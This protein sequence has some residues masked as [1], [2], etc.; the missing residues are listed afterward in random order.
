MLIQKDYDVNIFIDG[1]NIFEA[2]GVVLKEARILEGFDILIPSC[3]LSLVVPLGWIN[4]R[5]IVDGTQIRIDIISKR[6]DI[7]ESLYFRLFDISKIAIEQAFCTI[8]LGGILDFYPGYRFYNQFNMYGSSSDVFTNVAKQF[9]LK[10]EIDTTNDYQLWA[11]GENN[12]YYHLN[13]ICRHGW[14]DDVSAMIWGFDRHKIL[15][16]KNLTTMFRNRNKQGWSFIQLPDRYDSKE[17]IYGYSTA[18]V[19]ITSGTENL[20]YEGYGGD[21][22]YFDFLS[23]NWK[24]P[25]AKKVVAESNLINISKD[26]SQGLATNWYPFDVGNFHKNYWL[27]R[28]QNAR[29]LA[30][31]STYVVLQSSRL[32]NYRLGQ[33]VKFILMDSQNQENSVKMASGIYMISSISIHITQNTV[34][35]TVKLA[36]QGLNGQAITR[37]TY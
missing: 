28:K 37:E 18:S 11:S 5:S 17:K 19:N 16:Y 20:L 22:T 32:M 33:I 3:L 12:L 7:S 36:M 30:T 10:S 2:P 4:Q 21:D 6:L 1:L 35:S 15:L 27:A 9:N 29:I 34:T 8:E 26:L 14:V 24:H 13:D 25:S 31:Y 23:Y